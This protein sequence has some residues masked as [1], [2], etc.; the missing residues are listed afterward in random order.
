[1]P[2]AVRSFLILG[3]VAHPGKMLLVRIIVR[4]KNDAKGLGYCP[5]GLE[6]PRKG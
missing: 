3:S 6:P 5:A 1:M 2:L 4:K